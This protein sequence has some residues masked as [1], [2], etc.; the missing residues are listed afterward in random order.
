MGGAPVSDVPALRCP[1]C[2]AG[3]T[4]APCADPLATCLACPAGHRVFVVPE[5][6][7]ASATARAHETPFPE[8]DGEPPQAVAAFWLSNPAA[9]AMLNAQL[10]ELLRAILDDRRVPAAAAFSYCP[11]CGESLSEYAQPDAWVAGLRCAN[12]HSWWSRGGRLWGIAGG[13]RLDLH[14]EASDSTVARLVAG[15]LER[16]PDL[17]AQLHESVRRVLTNSRFA[18][19]RAA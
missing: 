3:L 11:L 14:A 18:P 12:A 1:S 5:A 19:Q 13:S 6:P 7:P 8:L 15:W 4:R 17:E 10:A 16:R 9:R 2:R